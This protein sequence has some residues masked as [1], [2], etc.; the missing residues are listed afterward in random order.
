[1]PNKPK[2]LNSKSVVKS[3]LFDIEEL[4]LRFAN[5]NERHFERIRGRAHGAVVIVPLLNDNTLILVREYAAGVD[6]YELGFPKG[7]VDADENSLQAANRELQEE[8][9]VAAKDLTILKTTTVAPGYW[10]SSA[11]IILARDLYPAKLVGDEPEPLEIVH[12]SLKDFANLLKQP[13]FT[14][15][16]SIAAL[17]LVK[18]LYS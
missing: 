2:I 8:I 1:M 7:L 5:G 12:W 15:A 11:D 3:K 18:D 17:L 6:R 9:G 4:H 10:G 13:D 14:E 16:R